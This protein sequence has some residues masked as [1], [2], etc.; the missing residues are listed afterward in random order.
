[1]NKQEFVRK[2]YQAKCYREFLRLSIDFLKETRNGFSYTYFAQ[3]AGF[4]SRGFIIDVIKGDKRLTERS[5]P[6]VIRGLGLTGPLKDFFATLV[7]LEEANLRGHRDETYFKQR[8]ARLRRQL[9]EKAQPRENHPKLSQTVY[10]SREILHVFAALGTPEIGA[11]MDEIA[12][13]TEISRRTCEQIISSL[14]KDDLIRKDGNRYYPPTD[15]ITF[16]KLGRNIDFR[17]I[18]LAALKEA[19]LKAESDF[20]DPINL[21]FHSVFPFK[22]ELLPDLRARLKETLENF[23]H[24]NQIDEGDCI[25]RLNSSFIR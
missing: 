4:S 19:K 2:T 12:M 1:M 9:E 11:S 16:E 13:R 14:E 18:Y 25:C 22:R 23:V 17:S 3:K 7:A 6:K 20:A 24:E 15:Q 8:L 5:F 21:Y 10:S